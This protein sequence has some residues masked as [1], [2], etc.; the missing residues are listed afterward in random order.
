M[1]KPWPAEGHLF[2]GTLVAHSSGH[3]P[4]LPRGSELADHEAQFSAG[5]VI[6]L[7]IGKDLHTVLC[8]AAATIVVGLPRGPVGI[9]QGLPRGVGEI[10]LRLDVSHAQESSLILSCDQLAQGLVLSLR[11]WGGHLSPGLCAYLLS[12]LKSLF[13]ASRLEDL[14]PDTSAIGE[15][16]H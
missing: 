5:L 6:P 16:L 15:E 7:A 2:I 4:S 1:E 12:I 11:A 10:A 3:R 8:S 13:K 9:D 14:L